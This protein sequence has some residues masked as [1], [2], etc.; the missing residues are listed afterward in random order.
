MADRLTVALQTAEAFPVYGPIHGKVSA[1]K[2]EAILEAAERDTKP[3]VLVATMASLGTA[4]SLAWAD[5][6]VMVELDYTP[7]VLQQAEM[8]IF[9]GKRP[10]MVIY[11]VGDDG[12][13]ERLSEVLLD[14]LETGARLGLAPGVGSVAEILG[15][16]LG[17]RDEQTLAALA[18]LLMESV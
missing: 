13:E 1:G 18:D 7:A 14:K 8:R 12:V 5:R 15:V 16:S 11:L 10:V 2:R 9:D 3:R 4:V 17:V 6:A